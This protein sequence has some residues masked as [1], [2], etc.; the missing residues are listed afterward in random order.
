MKRILFS[1]IFFNGLITIFGQTSE[2]YKSRG[3]QAL[4]KKDYQAA[5]SWYSQG[6]DS[7]D[8]YSIQKLVEIWRQQPNIRESMQLP[9]RK[10]F[11]CMKTI[12]KEHEP[13]MMRLFSEF[14]KYG[15]GTQE[16][17]SLYKYWYNEWWNAFKTTLNISPE[18]LNPAAD[19]SSVVNTNK[20]P[21]KS[22][23]S[24]RFYS[25]LTY[26]GSPTMPFG[27]TG[28]IYFDGLGAYVSG[29]TDSKS[30]HPAFRCDNTRAQG[31]SI[32]NPPYEFNREKWYSR[33]ITAGILYPVIKNRWFVSAGGGYGIREYYR[34]ISSTNE[35]TFSTGNKSEW[36]YNTEASYQG[37][38]LEIGGMVVWKKLTV[39]TGVNSTGFKDLDFYFGIG[40]TF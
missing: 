36:C 19:S 20:I 5:R 22:L 32:E 40:I 23:L 27:F 34:E 8:R 3:D 15:I 1:I 30:I 10:C 4:L 14:Y 9:M 24:N 38:I 11:N 7:C 17:D 12:T 31:I 39:L 37:L 21:K 6:L 2:D 35:Q 33:M 28:G 13:D 26:T 18:I 25:F 16:N 29:R